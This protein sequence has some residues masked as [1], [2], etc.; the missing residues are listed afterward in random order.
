MGLTGFTQTRFMLGI[1]AGALLVIVEPWVLGLTGM[2]NA[3]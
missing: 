3:A 2:K 1:I